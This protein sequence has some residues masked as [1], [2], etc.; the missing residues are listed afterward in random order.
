MNTNEFKGFNHNDIRIL[1]HCA[2]GREF[3]EYT[4]IEIHYKP[5]QQSFCIVM[6]NETRTVIYGQISLE[7]LNQGL[8]DI[9]YK[10]I[11]T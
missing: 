3:W 8:S 2:P 10:I 4:P 11:K 1:K 5:D 9:G 6:I 7:M